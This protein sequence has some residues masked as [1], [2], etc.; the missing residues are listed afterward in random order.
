MA[1]FWSH[2]T[3]YYIYINVT[4][5]YI[6]NADI[7]LACL[8][9]WGKSIS[10]HHILFIHNTDIFILWK[11]MMSN[12]NLTIISFIC[13][14]I[15]YTSSSQ[16]SRTSG[17]WWHLIKLDLALYSSFACNNINKNEAIQHCSI[18][19]KIIDVILIGFTCSCYKAARSQGQFHIGGRFE[20]VAIA[21]KSSNVIMIF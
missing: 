19:S 8:D 18:V 2:S 15:N 3:L 6:S 4:C 21:M 9:Y 5:T 14:K 20:F 16:K 13:K 11:I 17:F 12:N 1:W 7:P 10:S